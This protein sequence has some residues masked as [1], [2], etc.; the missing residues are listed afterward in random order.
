MIGLV[1]FPPALPIVAAM[2]VCAMGLLALFWFAGLYFD[3][4][5]YADRLAKRT[6]VQGEPNQGFWD[7]GRS[8]SALESPDPNSAS[9]IPTIGK[10][11]VLDTTERMPTS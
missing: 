3:L 5:R 10:A 2:I 9:I 4:Y 11:F 8:L 1:G 6:I 7:P